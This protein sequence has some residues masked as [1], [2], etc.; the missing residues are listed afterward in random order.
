MNFC[1]GTPNGTFLMTRFKTMLRGK[2]WGRWRVKCIYMQSFHMHSSYATVCLQGANENN[3]VHQFLTPQREYNTYRDTS[4]E[5]HRYAVIQIHIY[6]DPQ[7][8]TYWHAESQRYTQ[9]YGPTDIPMDTYKPTQADTHPDRHTDTKRYQQIHGHT[10][11]RTQS[12][13]QTTADINAHRCR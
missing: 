5:T 9:T 13:R 8:Q 11:R 7:T 6:L 1:Q 10:H 12:D 4:T 2:Q 3:H